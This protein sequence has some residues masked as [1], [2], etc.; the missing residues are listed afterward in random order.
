MNTGTRQ[1]SFL[2]SPERS[3]DSAHLLRGL[4]AE[5]V[6]GEGGRE[7]VGGK[8]I[9]GAALL[10]QGLQQRVQVQ[11]GRVQDQRVEGEEGGAGLEAEPRQRA[12]VARNLLRHSRGHVA[13]R[14]AKRLSRVPAAVRGKEGEERERRER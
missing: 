3:R 6:G 2:L 12:L 14:Q 13:A 8:G 1:K 4:H 11:R 7:A 5:N 10:A 9:V